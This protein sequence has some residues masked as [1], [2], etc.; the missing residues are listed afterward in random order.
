MSSKCM[1]DTIKPE[2]I[3]RLKYLPQDHV[4]MICNELV[5][6]GEDGFEQE[7]KAVIFSHVP[8][9]ERLG[10]AAMDELVQF[11]TGEKQ[12]RIDSLLKQLR[13]VS[14]SRANLEAQADPTAKRELL[15]RINRRNLELEAHDKSK[16]TE[17]ANPEAT[18]G[19]PAP[20]ATLLQDLSVAEA[21]KRAISDQ[22]TKASET[23]RT[24][25]RRHA[26]A[27]R[28][29]EKL[30]NFEKD[31]NVFRM[32]LNEDVTELGLTTD[33][34]VAMTITKAKPAKVR[35]DA[36]A[37]IT[38]AKQQLDGAEPGSAQ[39]VGR[40]RDKNRR[41]PVKARRP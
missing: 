4:E 34:L 13:E 15:E 35:E 19:V 2:E 40:R 29:L 30:D 5:G 31:F 7:I 25:E 3:E 28:L 27:K 12:R 10:H 11:Q 17:A 33:D 16:P 37:A 39:A 9:S 14:R 36:A 6:I 41:T 8:E 24:A 38:I 22:I 18:K 20:D 1:A 21:T 26:V 32:S 23:L